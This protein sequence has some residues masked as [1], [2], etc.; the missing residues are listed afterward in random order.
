MHIPDAVLT[1]AVAGAAGVVGAV[2]LWW[3]LRSLKSRL[4]ERTT[5]LME[6]MSAF[7]FAAQMV[8]LQVGRLPI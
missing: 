8:N 1:P 2:G 7:V 4:G 6:T 5:V 3:G